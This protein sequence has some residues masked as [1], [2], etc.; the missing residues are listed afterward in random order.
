MYRMRDIEGMNQRQTEKQIETAKYIH[1]MLGQLY[2][3]ATRDKLE[4]LAYLLDMANIEAV[5]L[6]KR[7][8]L[9]G[10]HKRDTAA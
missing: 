5:D 7:L 6:D 2:F 3:M 1:Q 8:M 4:M 10:R 9:P